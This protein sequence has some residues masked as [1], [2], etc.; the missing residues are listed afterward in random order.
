MTKHRILSIDAIASGDDM[1]DWNM[2]YQIGVFVE[3]TNDNESMEKILL[4]F[5][6]SGVEDKLYFDDDGHNYV[7]LDKD[8]H[9]PYYAIE[10]GA[11]ID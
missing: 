5:F 6:K 4:E 2:W 8:T 1:W 10:Y 3:D 7:I 9:Q 11:E